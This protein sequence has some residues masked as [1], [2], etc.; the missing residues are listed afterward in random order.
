LLRHLGHTVFRLRA[1]PAPPVRPAPGSPEEAILAYVREHPGT[2]VT[3]LWQSVPLLHAQDYTEVQRLV[4][5]MIDDQ[6][7]E[8][9][10]QAPLELVDPVYERVAACAVCGAASEDHPILFWKHNTPVV[11]CPNCGLVYA[12]PR[13]KAEYLFRR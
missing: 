1:N 10:G 12:N 8:R 4:V 6:T 13:W 5:G 2:T 9:A 3:A 11:R 7:L